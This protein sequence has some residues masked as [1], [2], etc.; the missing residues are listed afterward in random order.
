MCINQVDEEQ[1]HSH[2][3]MIGNLVLALKT[4]DDRMNG[5]GT[6]SQEEFTTVLMQFFPLKNVESVERLVQAAV[7]ELNVTSDDPLL[8]EN[9]FT[10]VGFYIILLILLATASDKS[11]I[12]K[13]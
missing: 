2:L 4:A 9:L 5:S 8:Y 10:E 12:T 11:S 3:Q 13:Y 7:A 6:L 1:Y